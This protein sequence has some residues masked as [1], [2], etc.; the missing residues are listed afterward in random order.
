M[1]LAAAAGIG[2]VASI[3]SAVIGSRAARRAGR[4][5][6]EAADRSAEVQR[7]MFDTARADQRPWMQVGS[8]A[9]YRLAD[10]LEMIRTPGLGAKEALTILA[11][12]EKKES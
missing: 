2:A 6:V 5:Q 10:A 12:A 3:G 9:V 8:G 4:A 7:Y 1:G 11:G